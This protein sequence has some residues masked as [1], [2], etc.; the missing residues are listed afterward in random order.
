MRY[1]AMV[2]VALLFVVA[3]SARSV[4]AQDQPAPHPSAKWEA[5]IAKFEKQDET[6]PPDKHGIVF[7]GSS[8]I[9]RWDLDKSFPNLPAINRGFGGS[10]LADSLYFVDRIVTKH[11]PRIV[12]LYAGDNDLQ[13]GKTPEQIAADF[14]AFVAR[15]H[16][17]LPETKVIYVAV[18]PSVARRI[19]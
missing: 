15:V 9:V 13:S 8:S 5:N 14:D 12:V 11:E 1:L 3:S 4:C 7:V 2:C 16:A 6:N 17:K 19:T 18:K 10:Q